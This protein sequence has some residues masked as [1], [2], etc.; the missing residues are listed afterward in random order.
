[1]HLEVLILMCGQK[2]LSPKRNYFI[3]FADSGESVPIFGQLALQ[4]P[5][6][7][8]MGNV[9]GTLLRNNYIYI[10]SVSSPPSLSLSLSVSLID[11][12]RKKEHLLLEFISSS[13]LLPLRPETYFFPLCLSFLWEGRVRKASKIAIMKNWSIEW[14]LTTRPEKT[15]Y[16]GIELEG[17]E[18]NP[19]FSLSALQEKNSV[20]KCVRKMQC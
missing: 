2:F 4:W 6:C 9:E 3:C 13:C 19:V 7:Y 12:C 1:M 11:S 5:H 18:Y 15:R 8:L 14:E 20:I 17:P 16:W 10:A